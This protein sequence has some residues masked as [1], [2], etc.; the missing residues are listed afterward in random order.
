MG[1][2]TVCKS[3][4]SRWEDIHPLWFNDNNDPLLSWLNLVGT[5]IPVKV[6]VDKC[7]GKT[8]VRIIINSCHLATNLKTAVGISRI[9]QGDCDTR[10]AKHIAVFLTGFVGAQKDMG[11]I[12]V[13]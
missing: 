5:S 2:Q 13:K 11:S 3:D 12:P 9:D 6:L 10:L 7:I 1:R 8:G 4:F